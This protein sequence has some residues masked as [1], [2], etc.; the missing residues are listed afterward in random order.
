MPP[1]ITFDIIGQRFGRLTAKTYT[2]GTGNKKGLW[3]C[4]CDCGG[5]ASASLQDLRSGHTKSCGCFRAESVRYSNRTHGATANGKIEKE[6][7]VWCTMRARCMNPKNSDYKFYGAR[8]ISVCK[9]WL[10]YV[11]FIADMGHRP[12][13][14]HTLERRDNNGGYKKSNCFWA[15]RAQQAQNKRNVRL[16][17]RLAT[18]I[19]KLRDQG[20][21]ISY[22]ARSLGFPISTVGT[23]WYEIGWK[24]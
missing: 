11:N 14:L 23:V 15:T 17:M 18:R 20:A 5:A 8:G 9:R 2:P 12:S 10:K 22:V 4:F 16:T 24:Q 6:F 3:R 21:R 7:M 1:N 13:P 19:R